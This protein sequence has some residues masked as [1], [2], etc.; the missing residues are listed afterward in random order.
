MNGMNVTPSNYKHHFGCLYTAK[1]QNG[2]VQAIKEYL[3]NEYTSGCIKRMLENYPTEY[4]CTFTIVD[5]S[6][7]CGRIY[8]QSKQRTRSKDHDFID[9]MKK[10]RETEQ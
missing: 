9:S 2:F 6:F 8:I 10:L 7:E 4:P 3:G 5:Q 1:N